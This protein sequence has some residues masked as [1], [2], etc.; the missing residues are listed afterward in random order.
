MQRGFTVVEL[1]VV[2]VVVG[3][4]AAI[5]IVSYTGVNQKAV[6]S[7]LQSDLS[8]SSK[9]LKMYYAEYGYYPALDANSCPTTPSI[10]DSKYCLRFSGSNIRHYY[11]STDQ[12]FGL[13]IRNGS[14]IWSIT[15]DTAPFGGLTQTIPGQPTGL[16]LVASCNGAVPQVTLNWSAPSNN[17]G[18]LITNYI[19]YRGASPNTETQLVT[20]GN[21]LTYLNTS[22]AKST[23]YYYKVSAVNS[24]GEGTQSSEA[25][26]TTGACFVAP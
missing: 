12:T 22:L 14:T 9:T 8:I 2:I 13:S 17:G 16:S 20:V 19:L 6:V 26:V 18:S 1:L 21:V 5:T 4:L 10:V 23:A 7:S 15:Q 24:V 3:V 25:S 11:S